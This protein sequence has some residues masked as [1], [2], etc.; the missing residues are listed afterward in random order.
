MVKIALLLSITLLISSGFAAEMMG[1]RP[2]PSRTEYSV[3]CFTDHIGIGATL[4]SP[5]Q[6]GRMFGA[7]VGRQYVVVEVGFYSKSH[8][9]YAIRHADFGLRH[10]RSRTIWRPADPRVIV[11]SLSRPVD[12][13]VH[14][15][16]PET[17]TSS[18][19]AGYLFFPATEPGIF[20]L[21][22]NANGAWLTLPLKP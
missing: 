17:A 18:A 21:D 5:D 12:A 8:A 1:L 13:L 14:R 11:S 15:T 16:L 4:V 10:K 9:S 3:T 22:Y 19:I 20:E 2:H 7:E 6:V